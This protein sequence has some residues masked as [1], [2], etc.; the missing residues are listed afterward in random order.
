MHLIKLKKVKE[1]LEEKQVK[2][3]Q[4]LA[5]ITERIIVFCTKIPVDDIEM[6]EVNSVLEEFVISFEN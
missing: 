3:W 2:H 4:M 5:D 1:E 6:K